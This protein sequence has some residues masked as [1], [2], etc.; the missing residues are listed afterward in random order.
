MTIAAD[1][2][3]RE[4]ALEHPAAVRAFDQLGIDYCCGGGKSLSEACAKANITLDELL[5]Q[6]ESAA[7]RFPAGD[8]ADWNTAPLS[9]L[10]T[11]IIERHH[12]YLREALPQLDQ[13]ARKV[14]A[15]HGENHGEVRNVERLFR[16]LV[17]ELNPHM[18]KEEQMLFPYVHQMEAALESNQPLPPAFFGTVE[19]PI[20]AMEQE[21]EGAGELL[22]QL[23]KVTGDYRLPADACTTFTA[24]YNGLQ[25][26]E[27]DLHHHIHLENNILFPRALQME[28]AAQVS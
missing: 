1:K 10:I 24:L 2:T 18:L 26:L 13:M 19:N 12:A 7:N 6:L 25:E 28:A 4:L 23:R 5:K 27:H 3:V 8:N 22:R 17:Q 14:S 9:Q 21:H 20:R 16:L 15:V 11:H